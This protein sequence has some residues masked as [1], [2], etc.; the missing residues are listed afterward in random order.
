MP[1]KYYMENGLDDSLYLTMADMSEPLARHGY[2]ALG[3]LQGHLQKAHEQKE[4]PGFQS[5]F[6]GCAPGSRRYCARATRL[7]ACIAAGLGLQLIQRDKV[8]KTGLIPNVLGQYDVVEK[9]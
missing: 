1:R 7:L 8:A 9:V 4:L 2:V 6:C 3:L 5:H